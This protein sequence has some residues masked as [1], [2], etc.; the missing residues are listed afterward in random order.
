MKLRPFQVP[1][2]LVTGASPARLAAPGPLMAPNSGMRVI[3]PAAATL[4]MP[5]I[6][7][8]ISD[9]RLR[10]FSLHRSS[11]ISASMRFS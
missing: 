9:R 6:E 7:F 2:S 5:G 11:A 3:K 4:D 1:D 8:R 10:V